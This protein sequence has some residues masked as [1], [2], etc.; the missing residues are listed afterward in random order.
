MSGAL[1][2]N[3]DENLDEWLGKWID[4]DPDDFG[5][6]RRMFVSD[7]EH[8]IAV[9]KDKGKATLLAYND[10]EVHQSVTIDAKKLRELADWIEKQ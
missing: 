2:N 9:T 5:H 10:G 7:I 1:G 4:I 8:G 6:E 3:N